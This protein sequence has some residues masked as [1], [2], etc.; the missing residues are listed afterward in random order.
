MRPAASCFAIGLAFMV[1]AASAQDAPLNTLE[2]LRAHLQ[3]C[4]APSVMSEGQQ[5]TLRFAFRANGELM[6][7]PRV[8]YVKGA[9]NLTLRKV[10]SDGAINAISACAPLS[11]T[12]G[13]AG[14]LAGRV[15][16]LR[17]VGG[18]VLPLS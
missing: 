15:Y 9:P 17:I 11:L 3:A 13:F 8:S 18:K 14:A 2:E 5:V 4:V 12:S 7:R 16:T 1:N 6:G 10:L